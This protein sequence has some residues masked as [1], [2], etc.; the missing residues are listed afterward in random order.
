M[1]ILSYTSHLQNICYSSFSFA[2]HSLSF[3]YICVSST[4]YD[5][6]QMFSKWLNFSYFSF[7]LSLQNFSLLI[8][9]THSLSFSFAHPSHNQ[10]VRSINVRERATTERRVSMKSHH[11]LH[12]SAKGKQENTRDVNREQSRAKNI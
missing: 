3:I 6:E 2:N 11:I 8:L 12:T 5:V 1:T 10:M 9:L 4:L 7:H